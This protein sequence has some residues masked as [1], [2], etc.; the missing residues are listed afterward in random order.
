M[1]RK[2]NTRLNTHNHD[3]EAFVVIKKNTTHNSGG[4]RVHKPN[5]FMIRVFDI[6]R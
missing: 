5:Y 4:I 3:Q 6:F 2:K 1:E